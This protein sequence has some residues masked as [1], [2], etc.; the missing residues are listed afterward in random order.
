MAGAVWRGILGVVGRIGWDFVWIGLGWGC[1][2][3]MET[4][5]AWWE[6]PGGTLVGFQPVVVDIERYVVGVELD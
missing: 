3:G 5:F 6:R 1:I 4:P 2:R